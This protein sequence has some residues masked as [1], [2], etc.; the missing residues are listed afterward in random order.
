M[1]LLV[2][3]EDWH[4]ESNRGAMELAAHILLRLHCRRDN[5]DVTAYLVKNALAYT[6]AEPYSIRVERLSTF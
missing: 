6:E 2:I 1:T 4:G 5:T 3:E